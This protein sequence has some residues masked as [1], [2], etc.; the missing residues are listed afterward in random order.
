[1]A[2]FICFMLMGTA[3]SFK[4]RPLYVNLSLMIHE[5][6]IFENK[7]LLGGLL[8][9]RWVDSRLGAN[10]KTH[11]MAINGQIWSPK[12]VNVVGERGKSD[13][14]TIFWRGFEGRVILSEKINLKI[15]CTWDY[16]KFPFDTQKCDFKFGSFRFL[17]DE[18]EL[19]WD[20]KR[21]K[22]ATNLVF[23]DFEVTKIETSLEIETRNEG[24]N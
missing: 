16:R 2:K 10:P 11:K 17:K 4:G 3:L 8:T 9:Q 23:N 13:E 14:D 18:V 1:M 19:I 21:V 12:I 5:L 7:Y 6:K 15:F 20:L 22:V 24:K